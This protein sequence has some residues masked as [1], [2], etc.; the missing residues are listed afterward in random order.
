MHEVGHR[1]TV[2]K[3]PKTDG[4]PDRHD[5]IWIFAKQIQ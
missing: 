1:P 3:L 2:T 5:H 4:R